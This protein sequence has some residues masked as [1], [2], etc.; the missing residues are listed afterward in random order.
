MVS[1]TQVPRHGTFIL[2]DLLLSLALRHCRSS[3]RERVHGV[4]GT[5]VANNGRLALDLVNAFGIPDHL[6]QVCACA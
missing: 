4:Y 1:Y 5:M 6:L 3:L 2:T